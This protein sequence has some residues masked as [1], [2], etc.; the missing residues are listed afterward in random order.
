VLKAT[1]VRRSPFFSLKALFGKLLYEFPV[2]D[3]IAE[4]NRTSRM[5]WS[6]SCFAGAHILVQASVIALLAGGQTF[7]ILTGG[8]DLAVGAITALAGAFAGHMMIKLG[9]NPYAAILVALAIG[10]AVGVFNGY[11]VAFV[12]IPSFI[13][14]LG[15]LTLW[16][17]LAFD[18]TGGFDNSGMPPLIRFLGYGEFLGV[19]MPTWIAGIYFVVMAFVLSS[20]KL[21]RYVYAMGSNEVGARQVGINIRWYKLS[22]YVVSGLSC[23]LGAIVLMGRMDSSSG[24]MAQNFELD[25]IAAVILGGTSLFGG[26]GS[27]WGSLLGAVL[28]TMIRNGMN[29]M[30]ISQFRQ[31]MAI[32]AVVIIAVWIDVIRR[33]RLLKK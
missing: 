4:N 6:P 20:T 27:I 21:G 32:G 18:A 10:A 28:I 22:V 3:Q 2:V 11:L 9:I 16:R 13:V 23:G 5:V 19:P 29:L 30:E 7:V 31:M 14:T 15:G 25:A 33:Q 8:V 12:G 1:V 26:R 17:G 24:K